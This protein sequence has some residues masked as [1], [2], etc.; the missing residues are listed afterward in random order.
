MDSNPVTGPAFLQLLRD[1]RPGG[2]AI[3]R[4][5]IL[6]FLEGLDENQWVE[7]LLYCAE[8]GEWFRELLAPGPGETFVALFAFVARRLSS[9]TRALAGQAIDRLTAAPTTLD[10]QHLDFLLVLAGAADLPVSQ[11]ERLMLDDSAA[12]RLAWRAASVLASQR[13][14]DALEFVRLHGGALSLELRQALVDA[15]S[16]L[17]DEW[18]T[19]CTLRCS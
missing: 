8:G 4:S 2:G 15:A 11:L 16:A 5:E 19:R 7:F 10:E 13:P 6:T 3:S 12:E 14:V 17:L 1:A 9:S 18:C